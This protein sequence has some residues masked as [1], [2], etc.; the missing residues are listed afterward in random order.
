MSSP[1]ISVVL[2]TYNRAALLERAIGSVLGQTFRDFELLVVDDAST[3]A[4]PALLASISDP[5]LRVLRLPQNRGAA[6]ARNAGLRAARGEWVAFQDSDDEWLPTK[7]EQQYGAAREAPAAVGLVLGGYEAVMGAQHVP[8]IPRHTLAGG[9]SIPDLLDGWPIITPTWL[10]RRRLVDAL[11]G[12]DETY[13]CLEDW[14]LVFR[15]SDRCEIRAVA[16]PVLRKHGS[17]DSVCADPRRMRRAL[18]RILTVHAHRWRNEPRR[19]ARRLAHLGCLQFRAGDRG[20]A[21]TTLWRAA[22]H[23]F[24]SPATHAL[25]WSSFVGSRAL[26]LAARLWPRYSGMTP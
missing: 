12:F 1:A 14:D 5:R 22:R 13:P 19:Y 8:I 23:D 26:R 4:T 16:G 3:D 10:V 2:P 21:W 17:L 6:G 9:P 20:L 7:L 11:G 25:L 15:L 18:E 24:W